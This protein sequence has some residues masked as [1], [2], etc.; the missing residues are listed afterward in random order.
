MLGTLLV[1]VGSF[2]CS[3]RASPS[4]VVLRAST[5][6]S[7]LSVPPGT[8]YSSQGRRSQARALGYGSPPRQA[9]LYHWGS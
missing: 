6:E 8:K 1:C 3:L 7:I 2:G 5:A 9:T 4:P